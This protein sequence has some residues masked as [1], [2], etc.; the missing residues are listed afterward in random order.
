[1]RAH[2]HKY[3]TSSV[4]THTHAHTS[5]RF[6]ESVTSTAHKTH[7]KSCKLAGNKKTHNFKHV[8]ESKN[9]NKLQTSQASYDERVY[10]TAVE[11]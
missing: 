5:I 3:Q 9:K 8:N 2:T 4:N 11:K 10:H 6:K 1:M 7:T